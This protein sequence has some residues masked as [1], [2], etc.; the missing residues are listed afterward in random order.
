M[1]MTLSRLRDNHKVNCAKAMLQALILKFD[2]LM[3]QDDIDRNG[4][5]F[6]A[7]KE[8]AKRFALSFGLDAVKNR[9]AVAKLHHEGIL[10]AV[11]PLENPSDPA[12]PPPN[13]PF[14]ELLTEF[15]NKLL[16]Q[17]KKVVLAYLDKRI[18]GGMPNS[19]GED[20]QPLLMYRNS[21][22]HGEG[23][24]PTVTSKRAYTRKRKGRYGSD[25]DDDDDDPDDKDY[26][27]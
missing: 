16:K 14:L 3:Q 22:V 17:D 13:L 18:A 27:G 5:E 4:E 19:R 20:W 11:H 21:L 25:S 15:T 26:R 7:I 12:A 1:K 9:E 23:E 24:T 6:H 10:T 2:V 8:L